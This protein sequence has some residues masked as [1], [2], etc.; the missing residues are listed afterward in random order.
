MRNARKLAEGH[1]WQVAQEMPHPLQSSALAKLQDQYSEM[2]SL[3]LESSDRLRKM[4][5]LFAWSDLVVTAGRLVGHEGGQEKWETR[6]L[7]LKDMPG[8]NNKEK[9]LSLFTNHNL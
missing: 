5:L 3:L 8:S 6:N 2:S 4:E 1:G 7:H 9:M